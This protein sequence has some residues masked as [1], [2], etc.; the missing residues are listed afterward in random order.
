MAQQEGF[1]DSIDGQEKSQT[2]PKRSAATS[3]TQGRSLFPV[4]R[5]QKIIKADKVMGR[6]LV[7]SVGEMA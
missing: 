6:I 1:E 7:P 5:M 2:A 4:S 3:R